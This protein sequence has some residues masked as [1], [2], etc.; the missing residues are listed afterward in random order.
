MKFLDTLVVFLEWSHPHFFNEG[1]IV[2]P[3][4]L[5]VHLFVLL[6]NWTKYNQIR[7]MGYSHEYEVQQH[8]CVPVS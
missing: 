6:P 3:S 4:C 8:F 5:F 1:D 2:I 7:W